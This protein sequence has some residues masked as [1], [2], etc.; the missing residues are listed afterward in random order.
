MR[1]RFWGKQSGKSGREILKRALAG[2]AAQVLRLHI[3]YIRICLVQD[4]VEIANS[5]QH[6]SRQKQPR[7]RCLFRIYI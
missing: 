4:H 3:H 6:S 2:N 5:L 7:D 1:K